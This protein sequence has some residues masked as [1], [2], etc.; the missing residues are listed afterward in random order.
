MR[1]LG[2]LCRRLWKDEGAATSV[3]YAMIVAAIAGL[4]IVVVYALGRKTQ[5][6]INNTT[7]AI[8]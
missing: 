8:P 1:V 6:L 7:S 3:E 5:N 2:R 4:V